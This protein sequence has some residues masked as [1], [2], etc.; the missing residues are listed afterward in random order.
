M[1]KMEERP[2][3]RPTKYKEEYNELAYKFCLLGATDKRLAEFFNVDVSTINNWKIDF[4]DFFESIKRGKEQ[5][6][7]TVAQSLFKRATGYEHEAV[8]IFNDQ[9]AP[10]K[11]PYIERYAPDTTA[12]IFW[13]KNRQPSVW[14]DKQEVDLYSPDGSMTPKGLDGFYAD[15]AAKTDAES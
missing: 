4:P 13:L 11:V 3:G 10:L 1:S 2:V 8:K 5:A 7:A 6:D 12:A 9:G 14:R 15:V